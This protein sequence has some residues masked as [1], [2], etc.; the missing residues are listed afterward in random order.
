MAFLHLVKINTVDST[1]ILC[2]VVGSEE[3]DGGFVSIVRSYCSERSVRW[4][5]CKQ[6][7]AWLCTLPDDAENMQDC[8]AA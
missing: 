1:P 6:A 3:Y 7:A 4:Q 8:H 2:S 5:R